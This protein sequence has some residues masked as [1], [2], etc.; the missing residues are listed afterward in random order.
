MSKY[1]LSVIYVILHKGSVFTASSV[2][3]SSFEQL[4]RSMDKKKVVQ[5]NGVKNFIVVYYLIVK[6]L[7]VK[8][9]DIVCI[10]WVS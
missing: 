10:S 3:E 4:Q 5:V 7:V 1:Q 6:N 2:L 9:F 8:L